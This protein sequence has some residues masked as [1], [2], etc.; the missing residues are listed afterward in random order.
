M[1][2]KTKKMLSKLSSLF[3]SII[4]IF[5]TSISVN[6]LETTKNN[7][8]YTCYNKDKDV[9]GFYYVIED[10]GSKEIVYCYNHDL[11]QPSMYGTSGYTKYDYFSSDIKI[12]SSEVKSQIAAI[13]YAGYPNDALGLMEKFGIS[14]DDARTNTQDAIWSLTSGNHH[15][16][17]TPNTYLNALYHYA[18]V[19]QGEY[20]G[21]GN[22]LLDDNV[23]LT[24]KNGVWKSNTLSVGGDYTGS[25]S[26]SN[27]PV[28]VKIY[29]A[30]TDKIKSS[31]KIGDSIYIV[32]SGEVKGSLIETLTY[33]YETCD[34][35][36]YKAENKAETENEKYQDMIRAE[37]VSNEKNITITA[38]D[39]N[40]DE[41]K[42]L[43]SKNTNANVIIN[44]VEEGTENKVVGAKLK[45][46]EGDSDSGKLIKEWITTEDSVKIEVEV[47]KT[48]TLV[49]E[50]APEGYEIAKPITFTV[51]NDII[52]S[53]NIKIIEDTTDYVGY[54]YDSERYIS[55]GV[56]KGIV[57]CI[58]KDLSNPEA[59]LSSKPPSLQDTNYPHYTHWTLSSVN[60]EALYENQTINF[61]R[62]Q[63][64]ELLLAGYPTDYYGY[65]EKYSLTNSEAYSRTQAV[66]DDVLNGKTELKETN[67][68]EGKYLDLA[69]YY[70][71]LVKVFLD[72]KIE[73][74]TT[75][76]DFFDWVDGTGKEGKV[77]QNLVGIT[78]FENNLTIEVTMEDAKSPEVPET[79][80]EG[81]DS[82]ESEVPETPE[83]E[84]DSTEPEVPETS[85]E[86]DDSTEP[87]V[88]EIPEEEE[89]STE[90]EV[91]ETPEEKEDSN[92]PKTGDAGILGYMGLTLVSLG[93][94]YIN[95]KKKSSN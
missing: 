65:K 78:P 74:S 49:E 20:G 56:S 42:K 91:P 77:Y 29:D 50:L 58:N 95:R 34:V 21:T 47:G 69:N 13:L 45:L 43:P 44:K 84:D 10:D 71:D 28:N 57:Y 48:Y 70:N 72:P 63:L 73:N 55:D 15:N 18:E 4:I 24:E 60:E 16:N 68:L 59:V 22:V 31:F 82:T 17:I 93:G 38:K 52:E 25:I 35:I 1:I 85:G 62:E 51:G 6:A 76:V 36:L 3:L 14:E 12:I 8:T 75:V 40:I 61:K 67:K 81:D 41:D 87:E 26:I 32:Y 89:D 11:K 90:P 37:I 53:E 7:N 54:R 80:E 39:V 88:P 94:L 86:E 46:Y 2:I 79:P 64:A 33:S 30:E 66:I 19:E 83:Q 92:N 23:T 5:S 9:N 27:L